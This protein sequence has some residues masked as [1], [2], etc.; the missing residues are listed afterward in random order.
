M[1]S[2]SRSNLPVDLLLTSL[3]NPEKCVVNPEKCVG[4]FLKYIKSSVF[5][6]R[7]IQQ[8]NLRNA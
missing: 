5:Y 4:S 2:W 8:V 6:F 1:V 7:P 3:V